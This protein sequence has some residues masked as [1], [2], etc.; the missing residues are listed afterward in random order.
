MVNKE[1]QMAKRSIII[2]IVGFLGKSQT[3]HFNDDASN[4]TKFIRFTS[5]VKPIFLDQ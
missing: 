3:D 5:K 1:I 2:L 4:S